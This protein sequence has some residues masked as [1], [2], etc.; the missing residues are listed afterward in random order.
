MLQTNKSADLLASGVQG[1]I[2]IDFRLAQVLTIAC[3]PRELKDAAFAFSF[4]VPA[5][6]P[7][8]STR[9]TPQLQKGS[10]QKTPAPGPS[11]GKRKRE[12]P[13]GP[14]TARR[15]NV[16]KT[17]IATVPSEE[18][19]ELSPDLPVPIDTSELPQLRRVSIPILPM[20]EQE[21]RPPPSPDRR[22]PR[23]ERG[24]SRTRKSIVSNSYSLS[25]SRLDTLDEDEEDDI[26][27]GAQSGETD[28]VL[29]TTD[30]TPS[31]RRASPRTTPVR[32]RTS[33]AATFDG[34]T[35][36]FLRNQAAQSTQREVYEILDDESDSS[37]ELTPEPMRISRK[38]K[39][40]VDILPDAN[41][42]DGASEEEEDEL[43]PQQDTTVNHSMA[44]TRTPLADRSTNATRQRLEQDKPDRE[45]TIEPARKKQKNSSD[46]PSKTRTKGGPTIPIT[47]YRRTRLPDDDPLGIDPDPIPSL[48]APDILSQISTEI[49]NAYISN[50]AVSAQ[51][52]TGS[53]SKASSKKT[54]RHQMQALRQFRDNLSDALRTVTFA[55]HSFYKFNS[56]VR[57]AKKHKREL[58][59][60]LMARRRE[61]EQIEIE[62]DRVRSE[63][64][65][66]E[67]EDAKQRKMVDDIEAIEDAVRKGREAGGDDGPQ[68][69]VVTGLEDVSSRLGVLDRVRNFNAFLAKT[70]EAL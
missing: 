6:P 58:R 5:L 68:A 2:N 11:T 38:R 34:G 70:A 19:D 21:Q 62:I 67:M 55:Q 45:K 36:A 27:S 56:E 24:R 66:A 54:L 47:I 53:Q 10:P 28:V 44:S 22:P 9:K 7:Q 3:R 31:T 41:A 33:G 42:E 37:D 61:R 23:D 17:P 59:E 40:E 48:N 32:R 43:S 60:E 25:R 46:K 64:L 14:S 13:A 4:G 52:S 35:S 39:S 26:A 18:V 65:A 8:P 51:R 50:V 29:E 69:A 30:A 1:T 12:T 16:T 57:R 63:H 49:I 15:L 20:N